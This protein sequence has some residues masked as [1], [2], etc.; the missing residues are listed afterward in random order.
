MALFLKRFMVGH[1]RLELVELIIISLSDFFLL[2]LVS[3]TID[4][5]PL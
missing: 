2:Q 5:D 4:G 1:V 3:L